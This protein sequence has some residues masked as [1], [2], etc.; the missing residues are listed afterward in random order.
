M[1][2]LIN[3]RTRGHNCIFK[4]DIMKAFD[5]ASWLLLRILL[6]EI[7]FDYRF[8]MLSLNNLSQSWYSV[9]VTGRPRGFVY[10]ARGIKQGDPLSPILFILASKA[11]SRRLNKKVSDGSV[12]HYAMPRDCL[13]VTH[14]LFVDDIVIFARGDRR[15]VGNLMSFLELY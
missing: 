4:L 13:R 3:R 9:L 7:G 12:T 15:S 5:R 8:I 10:V 14:L 6:Q 1:V 11:I 2:A